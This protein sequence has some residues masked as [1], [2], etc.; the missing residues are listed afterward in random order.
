MCLSSEMT[1]GNV[2]ILYQCSQG[3]HGRIL[4]GSENRTLVESKRKPAMKKYG[5]LVCRPM[6]SRPPSAPAPQGH[7][8][9]CSVHQLRLHHGF[10]HLILSNQLVPVY[11][12][13]VD[14]Q[15]G[16]GVGMPQH[17]LDRLDVGLGRC[18]QVGCLGMAEVPLRMEISEAVGKRLRGRRRS[19]RQRSDVLRDALVPGPVAS[20][21]VITSG[22]SHL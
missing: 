2:L 9:S 7:V 13:R 12:V 10:H 6:P 16:T 22:R 3:A 19:L 18:D 5:R 1:Y 8:S 11:G 4:L 14:V 15:S 21:E 20:R 17:R